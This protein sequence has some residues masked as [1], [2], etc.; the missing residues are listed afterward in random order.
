MRIFASMRIGR[1]LGLG[2]TVILAF[3]IAIT[4]ISIWRLQQLASSTQ[5]MMEVPLAKERM[6]DD[7]Y[8][9]VFAGIRRTTAIV[10]SSDPSLGPFFAEDAAMTVKGAQELK[11]KIHELLETDEERSLFKQIDEESKTYLGTRAE[12]T[13]AKDAGDNDTAQRVLE[14][15][16]LPSAQRY[17][18]L[19]QKLR[20]EQRKRLDA[21]SR[22]I[23]AI[24]ETSRNLLLL[25]TGLLVT[26]GVFWAWWLTRSITVPLQKA[27]QT[28]RRVADG[29]LSEDIKVDSADE[30]GQLLQALKDMNASLL[31]IVTEVRTGTHAMT[32]ASGEIATG[33]QD[34]S[35]RTE[36]Q[37]SSLEETASSME[38]LT[39][40]VRNN[41]ENA[42][43]A[44]RLA[45][46]ASSIAVKGGEVVSEVVDTMQSI[47][48]SSKKI[49][50]IIGVIDGIAFQTNILA[51]NAAVEAARAGEQGRGFAVVAS[52][53]RN[54]AQRSATAAREIKAL[55]DDSV[56]KV[57][58]GSALVERAGSTMGEIV[59][60]VRRVTG[61][62]GEIMS[63]SEEQS[64]GIEEVNH[65]I[66][67][68][69]QVTQQNAALVEQAAAAASAMREQAASLAQVVSVFK[70]A[71][72]RF[73]ER[74]AS[75]QRSYLPPANPTG[76]A[77]KTHKPETGNA[78][79]IRSRKSPAIKA[80]TGG[81][82]WEEI[83]RAHV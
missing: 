33:N 16:Y 27:V 63:A 17:E 70:T 64:T 44:N 34:L 73:E 39:A 19:V 9:F 15:G 3:A 49:V 2:F 66:G 14:Q 22:E 24:A 78:L 80:S 26:T 25:L 28:A 59:D 1:R 65:A 8:R 37:A 72:A 52:E 45:E 67:Q 82:E 43:Q 54:L 71:D 18:A 12:I 60:S 41:L 38:Q 69:D 51:L 11:K 10:K 23:N 20:D 29:H 76:M 42:R 4:A 21:A 5:E 56:T 68:M 55:I 6:I 53:V 83:G 36:E 32:I 35:S 47:S 31:N 62:M 48:A 81:D 58:N 30:T 40:A 7:W 13:K 50:D 74:T 61:I 57:E 75:E 77:A 46:S 79:A